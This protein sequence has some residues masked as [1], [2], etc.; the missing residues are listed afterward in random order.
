M[1]CLKVRKMWSLPFRRLKFSVE[2]TVI[3]E[4]VERKQQECYTKGANPGG[5]VEVLTILITMVP[6]QKQMT[7][8][9]M[10]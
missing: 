4:N 10:G 9:V 5:N 6:A 8:R 1:G 3:T 2:D 7:H